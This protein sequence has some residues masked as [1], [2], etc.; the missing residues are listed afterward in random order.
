LVPLS[1]S[2]INLALNILA[3]GKMSIRFLEKISKQKP[4]N[5]GSEFPG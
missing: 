3:L 1:S 5:H 4:G 2:I